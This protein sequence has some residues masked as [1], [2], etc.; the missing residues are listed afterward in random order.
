[1]FTSGALVFTGL[2]VGGTYAAEMPAK[3]MG[4]L[5][6][7][8]INV[9]ATY[10]VCYMISTLHRKLHS[11]ADSIVHFNKDLELFHR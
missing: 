9:W 4:L 11:F 6:I 7:I 2:F 8:M 5:M 10:L 1:M 3:M